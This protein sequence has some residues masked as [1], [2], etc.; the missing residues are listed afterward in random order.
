MRRLA[1]AAPLVP[2]CAAA[3]LLAVA[4]APAQ[5]PQPCLGDTGAAGVEA[6]PGPRV[7]FGI[8]PA[9]EARSVRRSR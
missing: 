2:A 4:P 9:G 1:A 8:T 6:K 3:L 5:G 7:R